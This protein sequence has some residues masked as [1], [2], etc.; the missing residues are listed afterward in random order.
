MIALSTRPWGRND[1]Q[2]S[3][4]CTPHR[5][6]RTFLPCFHSSYDCRRH[7]CISAQI[8]GA[9]RHIEECS[10]ERHGSQHVVSS[11]SL[12]GKDRSCIEGES[13]HI[14][15]GQKALYGLSSPWGNSSRR[16]PA[17]TAISLALVK[18]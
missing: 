6:E 16:F 13:S 2:R 3:M 4:P 11:D 17:K 15:P 1:L 18:K 5:C 9:P 14:L 7:S 12:W 10:P 8:E